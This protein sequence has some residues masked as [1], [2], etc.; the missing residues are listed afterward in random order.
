MAKPMQQID[1]DGA[2][3]TL[4]NRFNGETF[5]FPLA[6]S[7]RNAA[8]FECILE[9]GGSGGGDALL[10]VHPRASE[11]FRVRSGTLLI[12]VDGVETVLQPGH[13]LTID[14]GASHRFRNHDNGAT[15][16]DVEFVP[17]QH[18]LDFFRT[19]ARLTERRP[20]WFGPTGKPHL[21]L[22]VVMLRHFP[23]HLYLSRVPV[24]L[25]KLVFA[26]LAPVARWRG[27]RIEDALQ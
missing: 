12:E 27:Y 18:H 10:H 19:F 17:R 14:A 22:I 26:C 21:F 23:D 2:T 6:D 7:R 4:R 13:T 20:D 1:E 3:L 5:I 15:H 25:Q 24:R 11:T 16:F 9:Q 8:T